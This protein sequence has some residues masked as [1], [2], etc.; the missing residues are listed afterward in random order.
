MSSA[1]GTGLLQGS[2]SEAVFISWL[3]LNLGRLLLHLPF[4]VGDVGD[5]L[6]F[7]LPVLAE[8]EK[9]GGQM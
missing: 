1:P 5:R 6:S 2:Q 3:E 8:P 4:S 9:T 7:L